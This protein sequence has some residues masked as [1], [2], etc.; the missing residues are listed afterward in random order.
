[1]KLL[2]L[3]VL[4]F[5]AA[6]LPPPVCAETVEGAARVVDGDTIEIREQRIR[7]WGIDA[8]ELA[9]RC[10]EDG[11]LY[12]CGLDASQ[13]LRKRIGRKPVSCVRRDTDRYGRMVALCRADG[14]DLSRWMVQQGQA[15]AFRR[16]SLDYVE[17]EDRAREARVGLWAGE[18][19]DPSDSGIRT[20]ANQQ[21][22]LGHVGHVP[23]R[24]TAIAP[25]VDV[26][27]AAVIPGRADERLNARC[28]AERNSR[29][30]RSV[31]AVLHDQFRYLPVKVAIGINISHG[32]V[33]P[34][35]VPARR[36]RMPS[37]IFS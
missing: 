6:L 30:L 34:D 18:F 36:R 21:A 14:I 9:Q 24:M 20:G 15:I 33:Q 29:P 23:A 25:A 22:R 11:H 16:Y 5:L 12:P 28:R 27:G 1:M 17:D 4:V 35:L 10:T 19:Q 31:V 32:P 2:P 13:A 37:D 3:A 8:P 26:A 7:M